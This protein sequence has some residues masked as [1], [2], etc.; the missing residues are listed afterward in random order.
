[1]VRQN[2]SILPSRGIP[3]DLH[4]AHLGLLELRDWKGLDLD[5]FAGLIGELSAQDDIIGALGMNILARFDV[6]FDLVHN[7][8]TR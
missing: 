1:M 6:E 7:L 5:V 2:H 4:K 3:L 8:L